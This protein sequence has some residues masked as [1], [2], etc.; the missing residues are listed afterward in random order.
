MT[1][2]TWKANRLIAM[3][4]R[5]FVNILDLY[6][7]YVNI[8]SILDIWNVSTNMLISENVQRGIGKQFDCCLIKKRSILDLHRK[9]NKTVLFHVWLWRS[10]HL[11]DKKYN[12]KCLIVRSNYISLWTPALIFSLVATSL[13]KILNMVTTRKRWQE[14]TI[15]NYNRSF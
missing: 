10:G 2:I 13:V 4:K 14:L 15:N 6:S 5:T 1:M 3:V 9:H 7:F 8:I 11:Y 12:K